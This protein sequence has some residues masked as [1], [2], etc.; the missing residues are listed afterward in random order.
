MR[1]LLA[2]LPCALCL[3]GPDTLRLKVEP[4]PAS[5]RVL[6]EQGRSGRHFFVQEGWFTWCPSMDREASGRWR[7]FHSRWPQSRTFAG[8]LTHSEVATASGESPEGPFVFHSTALPAGNGADGAWFNAH[9]PKIERFGDRHWLHFIRTRG[10]GMDEAGRAAVAR[11]G[12]SH[13]VWKRELRPNQRTFAARS[14]T[15]DGPWE[16]LPEP[17]LEPSGPIRTLAVNPAVVARPE[18]GYLMIVKGDRPGARDF[19]RN[20]AVALAPAPY[21]PW[22]L[23]PDPVIADLDTEDVSAWHDPVRGRY[24]AVFHATGRDGFIG[25][26]TSED[27]LRWSRAAQFR[28]TDKRL[29]FDDGTSF[30]P[31][32]LERPWV[33][34]DARGQPTHLL[35]AIGL[36]S[37]TGIVILRLSAP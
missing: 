4:L 7:L 23:Q 26:V 6:L 31:T 22:R 28:L 2:W 14:P 25:M 8:W 3:A 18:G 13:A 27:G 19:S 24:Y 12:P 1:P 34:R 30:A 21:G 35:C 29:R 17:L 15:M 33:L 37:T 5:T 32:M 11:T 9:N 36:P 10:E 16:I 20:Q